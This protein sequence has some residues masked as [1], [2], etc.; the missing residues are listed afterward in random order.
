L[1]WRTPRWPLTKGF[2]CILEPVAARLRAVPA[3]LL[4]TIGA[5]V[6]IAAAGVSGLA[7]ASQPFGLHSTHWI[8]AAAIIL[9]VQIAVHEGSHALVCQYLG[10]PVREAGITLMLFVMPVAY[11]DRTDSYRV[12]SRWSRMLIA[13]AGPL[14]DMV[15]AGASALVLL[16]TYGIPAEIA[17]QLIQ[18]QTLLMIV[19]LNPLLPSDGY[20]ALESAIGSVNLRSRSFGYLTH[21][22]TRSDLPSHLRILRPVR[23]L[24]YLTFGLVCFGY[25]A[26]MAVLILLSW[27]R[28]L[29]SV[30][31]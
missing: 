4:L 2:Q 26:V 13:L 11:V 14:S 28:L 21:I 5:I 17:A 24:G 23:R 10:V 19:N 3:L 1:R 6:L 29:M 22:V 15:C 7:L 12:R 27:W 25:G 30:T 16:T 20:H 8:W 18:M 9:L 31:S